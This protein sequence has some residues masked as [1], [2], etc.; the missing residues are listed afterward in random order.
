VARALALARRLGFDESCRDDVGALLHVLAGGAGR[1]RAGE[2][3]TG[4][5]VG[6]AWIVSG[7]DPAVPFLT[8]ERD[9]GLA[10]AARRLFAG[11]ANVRV[12]AGDWRTALAD[13]APFDLLFVDAPDAT[14][15]VEA[16]VRLLAPRGTAVLDDRTAGWND[17]DP[18][19]QAW[20]DHAWLAAV[21]VL[22]APAARAI[23]AVR[24]P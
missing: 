9:A 21:E 12:L 18:R 11:D 13:E 5:G 2:V 8:A 16:T 17:R 19:R 23:V 15:D 3:G 14:G 24:R 10:A 1:R 4:C 7:L 22:T 6:A 20:L